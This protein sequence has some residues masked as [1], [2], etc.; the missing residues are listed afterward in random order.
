MKTNS[1]VFVAGLMVLVSAVVVGFLIAR[2]GLVQQT[3]TPVFMGAEVKVSKALEGIR[4]VEKVYKAERIIKAEKAVAK[5][6]TKPIVQAPLPIVPPQIVSKVMPTYPQAA[7]KQGLAG[8]ALLSVYVGL[9]G[10]AE[11]VELKSSSGVP[12]LDQAASD[13]VSQWQ[14]AAAKQGSAAIASWFEIP[15]RFEVK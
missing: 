15:V 3:R 14:F 5:V 7:L 10:Q 13:A 6:E 4:G 11:R 1:F 8:T 2:P 12:E 9:T